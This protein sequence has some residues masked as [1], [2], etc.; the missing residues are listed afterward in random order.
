MPPT[1]LCTVRNCREP[2]EFDGTR[3]L[4]SNRHSFDIAR[5]GYSNLLQP[6]D[7]RSRH[8]GDSREAVM[9]RRRFLDRGFDAPLLDGIVALLKEAGAVDSLLDVGCGEG[10]HLD[11]FRQRLGCDAYGVDI[12]VAAIDAAARR[13]RHC[14]FVVANA[15]RFLPWSDG[16][17][18]AVTS[19][20]SRLN[21]AE[22]RRVVS[23]DAVVLIALPGPDDLVELRAAILGE[24]RLID[25]VERVKREIGD[26]FEI[27]KA[28]RLH[29]VVRLDREAVHDVMAGSYRGLRAAQQERLD[30]MADID[31][32]MSRD[33]LVLRG[34]GI[35][36]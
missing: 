8:P 11:A 22:F 26:A 18:A 19:I 13:H 7:S 2:L 6:Q 31:V 25:R 30:A 35:R 28:E 27:V 20:T 36:D 15:D 3:L 29:H 23:A 12:S 24:G 14:Y 5:S 10:H 4:C 1:L 16:S 33:V 17:F 9:A 21:V 34:R 32:T